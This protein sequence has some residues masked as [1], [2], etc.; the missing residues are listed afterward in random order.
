MAA[1]SVG[2]SSHGSIPGT[3]FHRESVSPPF[4]KE[5]IP[6]SKRC[7]LLL[8]LAAALMAQAALASGP[9]QIT[10]TVQT[11]NGGFVRTEYSVR[12]GAHPLDRFKMVRLI[13]DGAAGHLRGSLLFLPPLGTTFSFY[14][15][16]DTNGAPGSSIAEYFAQRGYDVYGVSPRFEGIPAGI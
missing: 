14:E 7:V 12:A 13:R 3:I 1:K 5:E 15:Q 9:Y 2:Q 4:R 6:M 8:A 10:A 16:R 11:Q